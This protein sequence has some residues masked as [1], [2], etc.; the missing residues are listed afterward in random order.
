[1]HVTLRVASHV[2]YLRKFEICRVLRKAFC[3]GGRK[4]DFRIVEF[5]IQG[6]HIHQL[7]EAS[8]SRA[9]SRGMKGWSC[10]VTKGL[11]KLFAG[12]GT[13]WADRYHAE[14]L[15]TPRQVRAALCYVLNNWRK[16]G[17]APARRPHLL[18]PFSSARYF[19]GWATAPPG[20]AADR[21][22]T[23]SPVAPAETW[24]LTVGWTHHGLIGTGETPGRARR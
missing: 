8:S 4:D 21:S 2:P 1:V 19:R 9:L 6:D 11:N 24:L 10:R 18:D 17:V 13:V 20:P 22:A 12:E 16:H 23:D 3:E 7:C 15:R 14:P 5:S